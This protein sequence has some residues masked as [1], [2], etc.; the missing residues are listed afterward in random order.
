MIEM[1]CEV[2]ACKVRKCKWR[3]HIESRKHRWVGSGD[4]GKDGV[5]GDGG[6]VVR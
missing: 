5:G 3:R 1:W 6:R 4:D 2:C